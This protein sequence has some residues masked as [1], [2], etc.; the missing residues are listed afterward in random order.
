MFVG[1]PAIVIEEEHCP[2][3]SDGRAESA[4]VS[5]RIDFYAPKQSVPQSP[6]PEF[7]D[8]IFGKAAVMVLQPCMADQRKL[9]ATAHISGDLP[10]VFPYLNSVRKDAFYNVNGPTF[11][12]MDAYRIIA[13]YP[14]RISIAKADDIVDLWRVLESIRTSFNECWANR[15][16]I[17]PSN[18][19]RRKP[20]ALEIYYRLPRTNC[21]QCGEKAYMAF[22]LKLWGGQQ[23]LT[24]CW[25]VFDG[26]YARLKDALFEICAGLG[27]EQ[28]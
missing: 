21:G 2:A 1:A 15:H 16:T 8:D 18:E 9:R 10:C 23:T 17:E 3:F 14:H 19:L 12:F 11:T 22:A 20:P 27:V 25:P 7:G 28:R 24:N 13:V 5:G 26:G 4:V 6:P